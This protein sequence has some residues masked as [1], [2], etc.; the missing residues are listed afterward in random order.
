MDD[1]VTKPFDEDVLIETIA[2]H[3]INK[4]P[5]NLTPIQKET[6]DKLYDL[7]SLNNL[8]RGD[9]EFIDKM[10]FIFVEQ[11]TETIEKITNAIHQADYVEVSRLIH[12][13][14]PSVESMGITSVLSEIKHLE[15]I[16]KT[17]NDKEQII[18]LFN[19]IKKVLEEAVLQIKKNE[20]K[21]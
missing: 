8:G 3:T 14:K 21:N 4:K 9:T 6:P 12:K 20:F 1:Y 2:K 13:I 7:N 17:T 15:K 16:A 5:L 10:I 11:T 18:V 19:I